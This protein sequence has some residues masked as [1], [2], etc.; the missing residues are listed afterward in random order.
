MQ[1]KKVRMNASNDFNKPP[2]TPYEKAI[3]TNSNLYQLPSMT[4]NPIPHMP[5]GSLMLT[6]GQHNESMPDRVR[7][8]TDVI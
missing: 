7:A 2:S 8:T 1:N 4:L 6:D 5:D 3:R